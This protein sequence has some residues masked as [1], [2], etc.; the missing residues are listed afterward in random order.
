MVERNEGWPPPEVEIEVLRLHMQGLSDRSIARRQAV[1][2][3]TVRRRVARLRKRCGAR[4]RAEA[5]AVLVR[6]GL[7]SAP[8]RPGDEPGEN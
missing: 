5:V 6:A 3:A 1:S 4:T 2:S 8:R 7:L